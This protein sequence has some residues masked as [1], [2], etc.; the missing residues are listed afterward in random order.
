MK[1]DPLHCYQALLSH[2]NR[3]DGVF[4]VGV[5]TT[6]IYCRP[7]C[8]AK[9]PRSENCAFFTSS[10]AA[11]RAGFRPCLRCRPEL[12]PGNSILDSSNRLAAE[13]SRRIEDGALNEL[14]VAQL[15]SEFGVSDRHL[16]RVLLAEFG[17]TPVELAQTQRLLFAKRLLTDTKL[18]ISEIAFS[19]G[20]SSLRRFN[21]LFLERYRLSPSSLRKSNF[22]TLEPDKLICDLAYRPPLNWAAMLSFLDSRSTC[23]I[24]AVVGNRYFRTVSAGEINGWIAVEHKQD[25]TS[26]RVEVSAS[27]ASQ[28]RK[29]LTGVKYMFD[30]SAHP[31]E[32]EKHLGEITALHSGMRV[33]GAFNGFELAVRAILGQQVSVRAA[34][35]FAGR[36]AKTF[37]SSIETPFPELTH[38]YPKAD[39]IAETDIENIISLGIIRSRANSILAL[40]REIA[41]GSI[42]LQPGIHDEALFSRLKKLPGIGEWTAQYIAMRALSWPDAFP[43]TDLGIYKALGEN[44]PKEV[45]KLAECWRPWRAYAA[46]HLWKSLEVLK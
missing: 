39:I 7:I 18:S 37:G 26:L 9:T 20:F 25:K 41:V 23:G 4:F 35:T 21:S 44:R 19:S 2:D 8:T 30:L 46:M 28:L 12:A 14:S 45:L 11:E 38:V 33:P 36:F 6:G 15:A 34:T 3:F 13:A 43:H 17:V 10:A 29:V 1:L 24:E 22:R 31:I 5:S 16:R 32:I 40:A 42:I 27:L